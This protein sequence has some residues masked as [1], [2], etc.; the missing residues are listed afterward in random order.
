MRCFQNTRGMGGFGKSELFMSHCPEWENFLMR[1]I[2]NTS[3]GHILSATH[4]HLNKFIKIIQP[5]PR[6]AGVWIWQIDNSQDRQTSVYRLAQNHYLFLSLHP[7][8]W[9]NLV[10]IVELNLIFTIFFE[11]TR[12][13]VL[14]TFK[15]FFIIKIIAFMKIRN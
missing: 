1:L 3:A 15:Y 14:N 9:G 12:I 2:R 11:Q 4:K 8:P 10:G 13:L 5:N 7:H 6:T